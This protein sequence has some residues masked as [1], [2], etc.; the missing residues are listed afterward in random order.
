MGAWGVGLMGGS[1]VLGRCW[2]GVGAVLGR[3]WGGVGAV[4]GPGRVG[5]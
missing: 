2:G 5:C 4:L 3:C 1:R